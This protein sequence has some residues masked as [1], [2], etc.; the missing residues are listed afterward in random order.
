MCHLPYKCEFDCCFALVVFIASLLYSLPVVVVFLFFRFGSLFN[1]F[2]PS[3]HLIPLHVTQFEMCESRQNIVRFYYIEKPHLPTH[4]K[5]T[6][7]V[8]LNLLFNVLKLY[9][10]P[11]RLNRMESI[12]LC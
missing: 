11:M 7:T 2:S 9:P 5:H 8:V 1:V 4:S 10:M 12:K 6:H 3:F